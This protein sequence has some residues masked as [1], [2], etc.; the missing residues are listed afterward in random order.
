MIELLELCSINTSSIDTVASSFI[1]KLDT[2]TGIFS[3]VEA[4]MFKQLTHIFLQT[5]PGNDAAI[6]AYLSA[7]LSLITTIARRHAQDLETTHEQLI[8]EQATRKEIAEE[9]QELR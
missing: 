2:S 1:A 7:R 4:N 8:V 5:R 3:I 6:K 9:V